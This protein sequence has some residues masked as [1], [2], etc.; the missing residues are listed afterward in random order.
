MGA[1]TINEVGDWV[2]RKNG[3]GRVNEGKGLVPP[4][5]GGDGRTALRIATAAAAAAGTAKLLA[6]WPGQDSCDA[7]CA[8][9][10]LVRNWHGWLA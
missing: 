8:A 4:R 6:R 10:A 1:D 3:N 7:T 2:C 9:V 5:D